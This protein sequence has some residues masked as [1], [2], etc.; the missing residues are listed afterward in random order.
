MRV[1]VKASGLYAKSLPS[2]GREGNVAPLD[3]AEGTTALDVL[4][5]LGLARDGSYLMILNG[6]TLPK[7]ERGERALDEDDLLAIMPPLKGG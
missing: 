1:S 6:Q 7:S 4:D 3:I 5:R 2:E